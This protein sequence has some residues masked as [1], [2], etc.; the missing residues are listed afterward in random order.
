VELL[1]FGKDLLVCFFMEFIFYYAGIYASGA[2]F[3]V[4]GFNPLFSFS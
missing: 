1:T 3:L 2:E 4:G